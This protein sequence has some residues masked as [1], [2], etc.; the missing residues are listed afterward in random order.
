[1]MQE[2]LCIFMDIPTDELREGV[3]KTR[4]LGDMFPMRGGVSQPPSRKM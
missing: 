1:M 4:L 3:K 2:S